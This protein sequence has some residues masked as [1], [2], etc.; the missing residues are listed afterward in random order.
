[1]AARTAGIESNKE[2]TSLSH[3]VSQSQSFMCIR[4]SP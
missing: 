4:Q 3:Y 2:I 1:M